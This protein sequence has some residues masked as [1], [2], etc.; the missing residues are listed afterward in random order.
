MRPPY[1]ARPA[2]AATGS[3]PQKTI[4]PGGN[5]S[6][7]TTSKRRVQDATASDPGFYRASP[8]KRPRRL[9]SQILAIRRAIKRILKASN[10]QTVRQVYYALTVLGLIAKVEGEYQQTVIRLLT[11]MREG[12]QIPFEWIAD[13]TR[14]MRKPATFTGIEHCLES[15]AALYRRNLWASMPIRVEVWCE[16]D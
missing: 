10:P 9:K 15:T 5:G 7:N 14:W 1:S 12:G 16:K 2:P 4:L 3:G 8:I 11:D 6:T 13:N